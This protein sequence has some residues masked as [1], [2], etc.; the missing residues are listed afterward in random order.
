MID[1]I[2]KFEVVIAT[3][4][5]LRVPSASAWKKSIFDYLS[6]NKNNTPYLIC[7]FAHVC[8][9]SEVTKTWSGIQLW[10]S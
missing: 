7:S 4:L 5:S 6:D 3:F 8:P 1:F 10:F 2:K 9:K